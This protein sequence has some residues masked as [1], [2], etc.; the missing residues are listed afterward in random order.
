MNDQTTKLIQQL[1]DKFGTTSEM[2]WGVLI[3]QAPLWAW[4]RMASFALVFTMFAAA[5]L[6]LMARYRRCKDSDLKDI[7]AV[8]MTVVSVVAFVFALI[9]FSLIPDFIAA[10]ANPQCWALEKILNK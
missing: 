5:I 1:A 7:I 6:L 2:L 8:S 9:C 10:F 4:S 3:R